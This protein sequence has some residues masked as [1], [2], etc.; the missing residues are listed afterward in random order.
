MVSKRGLAWGVDLMMGVLIFMMGIIAFY[1]FIYNLGSNVDET[2]EELLLDSNI[3]IES[4][5]SEGF[6][7]N[8]NT[9][10]V[11]IIGLLSDEKINMTKLEGFYNLSV[12]DYNRT[13]RIFNTRNHFYFSLDENMTFNGVE[14]EG[15]G[16]PDFDR[17]DID[18]ENLIVK[19]RLVVYEN[20]PVIIQL[21]LWR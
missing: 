4:L 18:V 5:L 1:F 11:K 3:I 6:P 9:T 16:M 21:Y 13:R 15:F 7:L 14:V 17:N 8:W 12:D 10:N 2:F 20:K 19:R